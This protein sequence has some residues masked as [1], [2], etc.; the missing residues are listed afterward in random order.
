MNPD[1]TNPGVKD[2]DEERARTIKCRGCPTVD[3]TCM[4]ELEAELL[5]KL[6]ELYKAVGANTLNQTHEKITQSRAELEE[7]RSFRDKLLEECFAYRKALKI[8]CYCQELSYS[9]PGPC[10]ACEVL[11]RFEKKGAT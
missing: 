7:L 3:C 9:T 8:S 1:L 5:D 2:G 6:E 10:E 4:T 11:S